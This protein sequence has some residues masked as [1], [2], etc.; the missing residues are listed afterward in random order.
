MGIFLHNKTTEY[1]DVTIYFLTSVLIVSLVFSEKGILKKI[2]NLRL[3]VFLGE[4][5]YSVYMSH[6]AVIWI[7]NQVLRVV[8]KKPEIAV[9]GGRI[10]PQLSQV[11]SVA[12]TLVIV[13]SVLIIG[14]IVY[15]FLE[16]PMR[17][18]S[19]LVAAQLFNKN[20]MNETT[21]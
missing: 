8:L 16:K 3:L 17:N 20:L 18:K 12:A 2:F 5:S 9:A 6:T 15:H 14:Y 4:I 7:V 11:E 1:F 10:T 13:A 21:V 19:R